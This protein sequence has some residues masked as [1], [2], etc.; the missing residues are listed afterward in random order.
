MPAWGRADDAKHTKT[1]LILR[2]L[3][4]DERRL[5]EVESRAAREEQNRVISDERMYECRDSS[6][7]RAGR[8][9]ATSARH[10][11]HVTSSRLNASDL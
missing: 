7:M 1:G 9:I 2:A 6:R 3:W 10:L 4:S 11:G 5:Q 8:P